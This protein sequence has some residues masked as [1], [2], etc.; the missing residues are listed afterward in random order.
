MPLD[1]RELDWQDRQVKRGAAPPY[2]LTRFEGDGSVHDGVEIQWPDIAWQLRSRCGYV[3][4]PASYLE[5]TAEVSCVECLGM[6][7][8]SHRDFDDVSDGP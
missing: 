1:L 2:R 6:G 3:T 8:W 4:Y 7:P 5:T